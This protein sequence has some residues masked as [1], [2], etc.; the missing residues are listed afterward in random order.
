M[1]STVVLE[2]PA[3]R[4]SISFA[5]FDRGRI[6]CGRGVSTTFTWTL[7]V[8]DAFEFDRFRCC[9]CF[10]FAFGMLRLKKETGSVF[11]VAG[12]RVGRL[13]LVLMEAVW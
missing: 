11:S 4:G 9:F 5:T 8:D 12:S 3:I 13:A 6:I 7:G 2:I 10:L 1:P